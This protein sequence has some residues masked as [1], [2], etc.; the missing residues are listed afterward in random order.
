MVLALAAGR[1][2][3][4][5]LGL[6]PGPVWVVVG[7]ILALAVGVSQ[8]ED[9]EASREA[10]SLAWPRRNSPGGHMR[11]VE[12]GRRAL[13]RGDILQTESPGHEGP[14]GV[15]WAGALGYASVV[16]GAH[17]VG[18]GALGRDE[19][20]SHEEIGEGIHKEQGH[21]RTGSVAGSRGS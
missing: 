1:G 15:P 17:G 16:D 4:P 3:V 2:P 10:P 11:G 21:P 8:F 18:E 19:K 7:V 9:S 6:A 14:L 20:G 13:T 12:V 5:G